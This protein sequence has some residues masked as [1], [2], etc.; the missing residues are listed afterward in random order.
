MASSS[1]AGQFG[2]CCGRIKPDKCQNIQANAVAVNLGTVAL[3]EAGFFQCPHTAPARRR[4]QAHALRKLGIG[5]ARVGLQFM[6]RM[7]MSN[8]SSVS[9]IGNF[10]TSK[11][12][13]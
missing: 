3:D 10:Q 1:L 6:D 4:R 13:S 9:M 8:L 2:R 5:Q 12:L 7:A 11:I